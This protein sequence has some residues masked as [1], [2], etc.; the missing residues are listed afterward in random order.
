MIKPIVKPF[1]SIAPMVQIVRTGV[2][3]T[4]QKA[5]MWLCG[6][7]FGLL[8]SSGGATKCTTRFG[9][10]SKNGSWTSSWAPVARASSYWGQVVLEG[11][12]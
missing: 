2:D 11:R 3:T 5:E 1:Q 10:P 4:G 6:F 9:A 12:R 8:D 7:L